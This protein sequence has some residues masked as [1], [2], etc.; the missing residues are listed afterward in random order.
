MRRPIITQQWLQDF[1][2]QGVKPKYRGSLKPQ[3][4]SVKPQAPSESNSELQASSPKHKA[5]SFKP[6][7]SSSMIREP[8]NN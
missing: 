5:S 3:A 2:A 8:R 1:Y 7:A 6:H 4:P